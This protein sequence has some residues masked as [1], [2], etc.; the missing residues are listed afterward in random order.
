MDHEKVVMWIMR[1]YCYVDNEKVPLCGSRESTDM[2][3]MRKNCYVIM[4]KYCYVD[5]E[6]ALLC[7][8]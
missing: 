6:K 4:R 5:Q 7:G 1:K 8:S 3:I 2:W